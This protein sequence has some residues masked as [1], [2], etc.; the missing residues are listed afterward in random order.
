MS[1]A[2][3]WRAVAK[4]LDT[5][6][7]VAVRAGAD[8]LRARVVPAYAAVTGGDMRLSGGGGTITVAERFSASAGSATADLSPTGRAARWIE[9]GTG[10]G[11][12]Q[13]GS[14]PARY[15]WQRSTFPVM[16]TVETD[17]RRRFTAA[18]R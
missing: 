4:R 7:A 18:L 14:S 8:L 16:P 13:G 1:A 6:S 3:E 5:V 12:P 17:I 11:R 9:T 15:T 2:G 10:P